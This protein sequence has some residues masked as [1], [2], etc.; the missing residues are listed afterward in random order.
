MSKKKYSQNLNKDDEIFSQFGELEKIRKFL[1]DEKSYP[2]SW[3][4]AWE[5]IPCQ[6]KA[7]IKEYANTF[8][9]LPEMGLPYWAVEGAIWYGVGLFKVGLETIEEFR[10][11]S[12]GY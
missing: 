12:D 4:E 11:N 8:P 7:I 1:K 9:L 3:R 5:G 2:A 10:R 6:V